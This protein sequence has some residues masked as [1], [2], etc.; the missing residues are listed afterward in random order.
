VV[1]A[2]AAVGVMEMTVDEI[3][4]VVAVRD[5]FVAATGAVDMGGVM[6]ATGVFR[7]AGGRVERR[8]S[9]AV[10]VDV[11]VMQVV[12]MTIVEIVDV[13][14]VPDG[15]VAA[16]GFVLV[17][18]FGM[19]GA[20]GHGYL[21]LI[22]IEGGETGQIGAAF[23]GV[24]QGVEQQVGH[25]LV[26]QTVENVFTVA[27][28][29]DE[30]FV[31]EDAQALGDGRQVF[32]LGRGDFGDAGFA[33]AELGQ[34]PEPGRIAEGAKDAGGALNGARVDQGYPLAGEM[35][36]RSAGGIGEFRHWTLDELF[37]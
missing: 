9:D 12:Q 4:D 17:R 23:A 7:G 2:V 35:V 37:N 29:G 26:G 13:I 1:V 11:A 27:A 24:G 31:A 8:E 10:F 6:S 19:G 16:A 22:G 21:L 28:A 15:G 14:V 5:C 32:A 3:V 36:L 34:Q 20:D 25:V 18:M 30:A 33:L